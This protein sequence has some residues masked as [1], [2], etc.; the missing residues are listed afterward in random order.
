MKF[1]K[2]QNGFTLIELMI[3]VAIIGILAAIA[4]P[5]YKDYVTRSKWAEL[6]TSIATIKIA[7]AECAQNNSGVI[8][9]CDTLA[10]LTAD[11]GFA[12]LPTTPNATIALTAGTGEVVVTGNTSVGSCVV[13]WTPVADSNKIKWTATNTSGCTKAQ[14]GF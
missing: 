12:A 2:F 6:N 13:S 3:V 5:Q 4:I 10:K 11:S 9:N 1:K 7:V 8:T 14:T